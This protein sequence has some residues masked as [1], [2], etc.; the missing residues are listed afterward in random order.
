MSI[1]DCDCHIGEMFDW[2]VQYGITFSMLS[3]TWCPYGKKVWTWIII[4]SSI[5]LKNHRK[6]G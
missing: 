6:E 2:S 5:E 3:C 4:Y 1:M